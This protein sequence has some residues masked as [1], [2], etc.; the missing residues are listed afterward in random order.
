MIQVLV[1]PRP[2]SAEGDGFWF[3]LQQLL[4]ESQALATV[5][6][7]V[8][9]DNDN[10]VTVKAHMLT[11]IGDLPAVSTMTGHSGHNSYF[12]CHVC[13]IRGQVGPTRHGMYFPPSNYGAAL[14]WRSSAEFNH[15]AQ[16]LLWV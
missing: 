8:V 1:M 2:N 5:G 6:I 13:P 9:C 4:D 12:G 10:L 15:D 7:S 3:F 14:P 11:A 16:D